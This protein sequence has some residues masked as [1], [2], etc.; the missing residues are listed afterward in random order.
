MTDQ[1]RSM[2]RI[3]IQQ[4]SCHRQHQIHANYRSL[5]AGWSDLMPGKTVAENEILRRRS[6]AWWTFMRNHAMTTVQSRN[7]H[8]WARDVL[9]PLRSRSRAFR[10]HLSAIVVAPAA[11]PS[12]WAVW[13]TVHPL[14]A[15]VVRPRV[16]FYQNCNSYYQIMCTNLHRSHRKVL[17]PLPGRRP[18][19]ARNL[20]FEDRRHARTWRI[21]FLT[22]RDLRE[23]LRALPLALSTST[24]IMALPTGSTCIK[25]ILQ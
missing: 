5:H 24:T 1:S 8:S 19:V 7:G 18:V 21:D 17:E 12:F 9:S 23:V 22:V 25:K 16:Q 11:D 6:Q 15:A 4:H 13:H 20:P 2:L 10:Y 3:F 14:L